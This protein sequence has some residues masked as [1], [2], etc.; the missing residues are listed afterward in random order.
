MSISGYSELQR[1]IAACL[2][3]VD[4]G[5]GSILAFLAK[6]RE[7]DN[8]I[9]IYSSDNGFFQ[10]AERTE[11]QKSYVLRSRS[12]FRCLSDAGRSSG[13]AQP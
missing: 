12:V 2:M 9:I 7:L 4:E 3:S 13:P 8:T 6:T 5:L 10:R 1:C 11:R